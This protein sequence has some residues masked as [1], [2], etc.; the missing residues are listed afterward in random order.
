MDSQL[1]RKEVAAPP[2]IDIRS[3]CAA[4]MAARERL[5]LVAIAPC[6]R[7]RAKDGMSRLACDPAVKVAGT[8]RRTA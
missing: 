1:A 6:R 4:E 7:L 2:G 5:P 3:V 8:P